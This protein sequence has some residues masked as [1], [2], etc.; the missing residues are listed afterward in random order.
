MPGLP[1]TVWITRFQVRPA[2]AMTSCATSAAARTTDV[3]LRARLGTS[4]RATISPD[5]SAAATRMKLRP[6][7]IPTTYPALPLGS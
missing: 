5:R 1:T 6:T 4:R 3:A 2:S 7:S